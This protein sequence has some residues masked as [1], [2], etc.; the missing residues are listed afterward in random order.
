MAGREH[1][2]GGRLLEREPSGPMN[3]KILAFLMTAAASV[4]LLGF[5]LF[6]EEFVKALV[7]GAL[8]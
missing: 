6:R 4:T 7:N 3:F 8:L 1:E 2:G 5:G